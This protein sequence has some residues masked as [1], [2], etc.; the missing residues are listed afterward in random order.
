MSGEKRRSDRIMFSIAIA[1]RGTD[2]EGHPFVSGGRTITVNRH[3]ARIQAAHPLHT[4]R[5]VQIVN[6]DTFEEADFRVVGPVSPPME[7][8]GE[9][10]VECL[11]EKRNIWGI[12]FPAPTPE[13]E[14]RGLIE[15]RK[16]HRIALTPLSIVEVEVLETAGILSKHCE[17]CGSGTLQ[18]Y[19]EEKFKKEFQALS[20][21]LPEAR[22]PPQDRRNY[23]RAAIQAPARVRDYYGQIDHPQTENF[24]KDG[25]CFTTPKKYHLGQA[26]MIL[27]PYSPTGDK[28]ETR[29]RV[30]REEPVPGTHRHLYGI[31]Y[32][33]AAT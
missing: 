6:Q 8:V 15:C 19:P 18:G 16:C 30:I 17:A 28:R 20:A 1:I 10:G 13:A 14:A 24:S 7:K 33:S 29:A 23:P 26:V 2:P 31:R 32:E 3:G 22:L 11:D 12:Y 27:C 9:W 4:G 21:L 25:I 5:T